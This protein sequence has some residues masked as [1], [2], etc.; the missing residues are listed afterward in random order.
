[1]GAL[2]IMLLDEDTRKEM[3]RCEPYLDTLIGLAMDNEDE[4]PEAEMDIFRDNRQRLAMEMAVNCILRHKNIDALVK[5]AGGKTTVPKLADLMDSK[6]S[7]IQLCAS[8]IFTVLLNTPGVPEAIAAAGHDQLM[9]KRMV[10]TLRSIVPKLHR[11][12]EMLGEASKVLVDLVDS[13]ASAIWKSSVSCLPPHGRGFDMEYLVKLVEAADSALQNSQVRLSHHALSGVFAQMSRDKDT[14]A[15]LIKIDCM[16]PMLYKLLSTEQTEVRICA[17]AAIGNLGSHAVEEAD[18]TL[19]KP[20]AFLA[21]SYREYLAY[22]VFEQMQRSVLRG[23]PD[24]GIEDK[25]NLHHRLEMVGA[26]ATMWLAST[27]KPTREK[28]IVMDQ[29]LMMIDKATDVFALVYFMPA[30][31]LMARSDYN[32]EYMVVAPPPTDRDEDWEFE[33]VPSYDRH[34]QKEKLEDNIT[35]AWST[36]M[37]KRASGRDLTADVGIELLEE[38]G[39]LGPIGE[40]PQAEEDEP[41]MDGAG[42]GEERTPGHVGFK[43]ASNKEEG[44]GEERGEEVRPAGRGSAAAA[45]SY[46]VMRSA[47][48]KSLKKMD[49]IRVMNHSWCMQ[50]LCGIATG[51]VNELEGEVS[52]DS[53]VAQMFTYWTGALWLIMYTDADTPWEIEN[54]FELRDTAWWSVP[55]REP[56]PALLKH[57]PQV[58]VGVVDALVKVCKVSGSGTY[59][60]RR[61]VTGMLWNVALLDFGL[62][63]RMVKLGL[64]AKLK[65]TAMDDHAHYKLRHWSAAFVH[66]LA[67]RKGGGGWPLISD[68]AIKLMQ[69]SHP[70]L[71]QQ[72]LRM[73][74]NASH[75]KE[76][77][78]ALAGRAVIPMLLKVLQVAPLL[79]V[80][81][82]LA[83][84]PPPLSE[85]PDNKAAKRD[86]VGKSGS[87]SPSTK[88]NT[89]KPSALKRTVM[90]PMEM[91]DMERWISET[92]TNPQFLLDAPEFDPHFGELHEDCRE[93]D[94]TPF[95][96]PACL[97]ALFSLLN[98]SRHEHNQA[99]IAKK[100]YRTVMNTNYCFKAIYDEFKGPETP[101][102]HYERFWAELMCHYSSSVLHNIS[103]LAQNRT[104]LY[105]LQLDMRRQEEQEGEE[106]N[107]LWNITFRPDPFNR[108]AIGLI[109]VNST[110]KRIR[111]SVADRMRLMKVQPRDLGRYTP[112]LEEAEDMAAE[113]EGEGRDAERR[114]EADG[115]PRGSQA[116]DCGSQNGSVARSGSV[117]SLSSSKSPSK[118]NA[119]LT[120]S[121]SKTPAVAA[122]AVRP[123]TAPE[124]KPERSGTSS[125]RGNK[126]GPQMTKQGERRWH[127]KHSQYRSPQADVQRKSR[128]TIEDDHKRAEFM[129]WVDDN[130]L[131]ITEERPRYMHAL[132]RVKPDDVEKVNDILEADIE[133][134]AP[135]KRLGKNISKNAPV[136]SRLPNEPN[137]GPRRGQARWQPDV[138]SY[139]QINEAMEQGVSPVVSKLLVTKRPHS[140]FRRL[141]DAA[142]WVAKAAAEDQLEINGGRVPRPFSNSMQDLEAICSA[143]G[144]DDESEEEI[145]IHGARSEAGG[146]S[147]AG[148]E[149]GQAGEG[150]DGGTR[151]LARILSVV[152]KEPRVPG[153]VAP[154]P[155]PEEGEDGGQGDKSKLAASRTMK[156]RNMKLAQPAEPVPEPSSS[157]TGLPTGSRLRRP[158]SRGLSNSEPVFRTLQRP[159]TSPGMGTDSVFGRTSFSGSLRSRVAYSTMSQ[160]RPTRQY[161][162][163]ELPSTDFCMRERLPTSA[164]LWMEE[165]SDFVINGAPTTVMLPPL[166]R[167]EDEQLVGDDLPVNVIMSSGTAKHNIRF[168]RSLEDVVNTR[169][170][171]LMFEHKPGSK[172]FYTLFPYYLLPNGS[173]AFF[174]YKGKQLVDEVAFPLEIS[175]LRPTTLASLYRERLPF[176]P[177]LVEEADPHTLEMPPMLRPVPP[178]GLPPRQHSLD[179]MAPPEYFGHLRYRPMQIKLIPIEVSREEEVEIQEDAPEGP[180]WKI[181]E[182]VW[183]TRPKETDSRDFW[184]N[185]KVYEKGHVVD[186]TKL[187]AKE[188]FMNFLDREATKHKT[189]KTPEEVKEAVA[190][191]IRKEWELISKMYRYYSCLSSHKPSGMP[192]N[193]WTEL[194]M[195]VE[196][197]NNESAHCKVSDCDTIFITANYT[198]TKEKDV[199]ETALGRF[200]FIEALCRL[201]T[202]KYP[203]APDDALKKLFREHFHPKLPI[204][205][206]YDCNK[207]RTERFYNEEMDMFLTPKKRALEALYSRYRLPPRGGGLR[208]KQMMMIDW[209]T[210]CSDCGLYSGHFTE[211]TARMCFAYAKPT[212]AQE[213]ADINKY[214]SMT[215]F[216]FMEALAH[217][218]DMIDLP[219]KEDLNMNGYNNVLEY[220]QQVTMDPTLAL[221]LRESVHFRAPKTR[222]LTEKMECLIDLLFRKLDY[223]DTEMYK[224]TEA[225]FIKKMGQIDR[226]LG[227]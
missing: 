55:P 93:R 53:W 35:T 105:R 28:P 109:F 139:R 217:M 191:S 76:E 199:D 44:E 27:V 127:S 153:V 11:E 102:E 149:E 207:F 210:L 65:E 32:R 34:K 208:P 16:L 220:H 227:P 176:D 172:L 23:C 20:T 205:A 22:H 167:D 75:Q 209:L 13:N 62:E 17:V 10:D 184:D 138:D 39:V 52:E 223:V 136:W 38:T 183:A 189:K 225:G 177:P 26:C 145:D 120:K 201:A 95:T 60:V 133:A 73:M 99:V 169:G 18:P 40:K 72:G 12:T 64:P 33:Y 61:L 181:E 182:S 43:A 54:V 203:S 48:H 126:K 77:K 78:L 221:D 91:E 3:Y 146:V 104:R 131:D 168:N 165:E 206:C 80:A 29:L 79:L 94:D 224:F 69:S 51:H 122:C 45:R 108:P 194:L 5:F 218:A 110:S 226:A 188:K 63:M 214:M 160:M 92:V 124:L 222:P 57:R 71:V 143:W 198:A 107:P 58:T 117:K 24:A 85:E 49:G 195:T 161:L 19:P 175:P 144:D 119:K 162:S 2:S 74:V 116:G 7:Y 41:D 42:G 112:E 171:T 142:E 179:V 4:D 90:P 98:L 106:F 84:E 97:F 178:L 46:K 30:L 148:E 15:Q 170:E 82:F 1:M 213:F 68:V 37:S 193:D 202:A 59:T 134:H 159:Q 87:S 137:F 215:V 166:N 121:L 211:R 212:M 81:D 128:K 6:Q 67:Q 47:R 180:A 158:V 66:R 216:D 25:D 200:Q 197:P 140:A 123:S 103:Q 135:L 163:T 21:G 100:G 141:A 8:V 132:P 192:L 147:F 36:Q 186:W 130:D 129:K 14:A 83:P 101:E 9:F 115:S 173:K 86:G 155:E 50:L 164:G 125:K 219:T 96:K 114:E 89:K 70:L 111:S 151:A 113:E 154:E 196:I 118:K 150:G 204:E 174:Y 190:T 56:D 187:Q 156:A 88:L 157:P 185:E 31:W 152:R